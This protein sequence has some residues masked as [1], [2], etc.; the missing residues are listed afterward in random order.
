MLYVQEEFPVN[1]D[2][3]RQLKLKTITGY[4]I[5]LHGNTPDLSRDREYKNVEIT[6]LAPGIV[7][8]VDV[9]DRNGKLIQKGEYNQEGNIVRETSFEPDGRK[10]FQ[11]RF[12][13]DERG[14]RIEKAMFMAD[15]SL[16]Y[17]FV[18]QRNGAGRIIEDTCIDPDGQILRND[19]YTYDD[20]GNLSRMDMGTIGEWVFEYDPQNKLVKKYAHLIS[21][22]PFGEN[23]EFEYGENGQLTEMHYLNYK[24][25]RFVCS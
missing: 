2:T 11:F 17:K 18:G 4:S 24:K 9:Y 16:R 13:Y 1:R 7:S 3:A 10:K 19:I 21:Q 14:N 12:T 5:D 25:T 23:Y 20:N 22:G 8:G 6:F 15:N